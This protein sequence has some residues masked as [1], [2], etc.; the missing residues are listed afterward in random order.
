MALNHGRLPAAFLCLALLALPACMDTDRAP[1]DD[2][3]RT[4][5]EVAIPGARTGVIYAAAGPDPY[6]AELHEI[7]LGSTL[8]A[9]RLTLR[10]RVSEVTASDAMVIVSNARGL[11]GDRIELFR[12][13][14]FQPVPRLGRPYAFSPTIAPDGRFLALDRPSG[15]GNRVHTIVVMDLRSGRRARVFR[16]TDP[17]GAPG[18]LAWGADERL[19]FPIGQR[20]QRTLVVVSPDGRARRIANATWT[21]MT[22]WFPAPLIAFSTP[23]AFRQGRTVLLRPSGGVVAEI[24]GWSAVTW[25]ADGEMLLVQ[26]RD[27]AL[28]AALGPD[29]EV[30][31]LGPS[32]V[33]LIYSSSIWLDAPVPGVVPQRTDAPV[34]G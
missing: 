17:R 18:E 16:T 12:D 33:G 30:Q 26:R 3:A 28:G 22:A 15:P 6:N 20:E 14:R 29:W 19:A 8:C 1:V 23:L 4:C 13:G 10:A 32:P 5:A 21:S 27:G 25:S 31:V 24:E 7:E 34:P 9:R 11:I 2:G